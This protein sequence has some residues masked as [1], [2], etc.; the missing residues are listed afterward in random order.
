MVSVCERVPPVSGV[1]PR[2]ISRI[3]PGLVSLGIVKSATIHL[4]RRSLRL[5][6]LFSYPHGA[7]LAALAAPSLFRTTFTARGAAALRH[8]LPRGS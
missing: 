5:G 3:D 6:L 4:R 7:E 8:S 1:A 2:V